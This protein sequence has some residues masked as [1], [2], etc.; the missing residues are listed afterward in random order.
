MKARR[1][2]AVGTVQ[3]AS[4]AV[5]PKEPR[6]PQQS[7][8]FPTL[9]SHRCTVSRSAYSGRLLYVEPQHAVFCGSSLSITFTSLLVSRGS[10]VRP[11]NGP[12]TSQGLEMRTLRSL[13][14]VWLFPLFAD[15]GAAAT[16]LFRQ[17][18][19]PLPQPRSPSGLTASSVCC[20]P[21][22]V[23]PRSRRPSLLS[24]AGTGG[25]QTR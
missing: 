23:L 11:L 20:G 16:S 12:A 14:V 25:P 8:P 4:V 7:L 9:G 10:T 18:A 5:A 1:C 13:P 22:P 2:V 15:R 21:G 3:L 6:G 24:Q 17:C 19:G